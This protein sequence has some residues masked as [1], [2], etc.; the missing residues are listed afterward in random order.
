[1]TWEHVIDR[2]SQLLGENGQGLALSMFFLQSG[3]GRLA[4]RMGPQTQHGG[5]GER[6]LQGHCRWWCR[7]SRSVS[8]QMPWHT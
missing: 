7:R 5:F 2:A 1:M 3:Q 6:P 4:S 8:P